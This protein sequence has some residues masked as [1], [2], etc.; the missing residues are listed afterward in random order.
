V[1]SI[2]DV[3]VNVLVVSVVADLVDL[4]RMYM[5][6]HGSTRICTWKTRE[7]GNIAYKGRLNVLEVELFSSPIR[8]GRGRF[9]PASFFSLGE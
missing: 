6:N 2:D 1:R 7:A 5:E 9:A 4:T 3:Q 8:A